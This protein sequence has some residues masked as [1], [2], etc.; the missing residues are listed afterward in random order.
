MTNIL[1]YITFYNGF[2]VTVYETF[3]DERINLYIYAFLCRICY[4]F[5]EISKAKIFLH[6]YIRYLNR[7]VFILK[8]KYLP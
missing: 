1:N 8:L 4:S 7:Q 3:Q 6:K 2:E 5:N